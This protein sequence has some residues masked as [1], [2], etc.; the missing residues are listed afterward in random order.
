[1]ELSVLDEIGVDGMSSVLREIFSLSTYVSRTQMR[2]VVTVVI[3]AMQRNVQ[4]VSR[5]G[6]EILVV[7]Y[8]QRWEKSGGGGVAKGIGKGSKNEGWI[9]H[10]NAKPQWINSL[11]RGI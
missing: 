3:A 4:V 2:N 9:Q 8:R 10:H 1:M 11:D 6:F 5:K 7:R